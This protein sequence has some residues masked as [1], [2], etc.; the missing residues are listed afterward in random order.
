MKLEEAIK[1]LEPLINRRLGDLATSEQME[2]IIKAKGRMGQLLEILLGLK[3][4]NRNLDF[5]D[6]ELKTNKCDRNGNP[7]ETMYIT[8]ISSIIDDL[9]MKKDFFETHIYEKISNILYV[10]ICKEG[11]PE[12]W[13]ILPY[14]HI[15]LNTPQFKEV[16]E[17]IENDYYDICGK[18]VNHINTSDDGF[19]HT[20][21]GDYIQI[22]SKDSKP[23]NPIFSNIYNRNISNKNH[24]FYFKRD[25]MRHISKIT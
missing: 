3:N 16:R 24:A 1:R 8:Q 10:P 21:S 7:L 11:N 20:S 2:G 19:I 17:Q 12:D 14:T 13:F 6:G 22:R 15:E 5:I 18:L 9:I 23:Y 25:F 4:T